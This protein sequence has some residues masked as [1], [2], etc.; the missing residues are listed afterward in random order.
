MPGLNDA[1]IK[2]ILKYNTM[3]PYIGQMTAANL[4]GAYSDVKRSRDWDTPYPYVNVKIGTING[5]VICD[6]LWYEMSYNPVRF[7]AASPFVFGGRNNIYRF[8]RTHVD[9]NLPAFDVI[10]EIR[11]NLIGFMTLNANEAGGW[12][13]VIYAPGGVIPVGIN[14]DDYAD[15]AYKMLAHLRGCIKAIARQNITDFSKKRGPYRNAIIDVA[16][17][18]HPHGTRGIGPRPKVMAAPVVKSSTC[19]DME[20]DKDDYLDKMQESLEITLANAN[21]VSAHVYE[22]AKQD[23]DLLLT[24]RRGEYQK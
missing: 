4:H 2:N 3:R 22:Q 24:M 16:T 10:A 7:G 13:D 8:C 9:N 12:N 5:N 15:D 20:Y 11:H 23:Y 17:R 18:R 1:Q 14:D 19:M 21:Y 6:A